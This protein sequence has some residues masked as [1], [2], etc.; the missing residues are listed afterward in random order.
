MM[1]KTDGKRSLLCVAGLFVSII[2]P[3]MLFVAR[4]LGAAYNNYTFGVQFAIVLALIM[5][6]GGLAL[7]IAGVVIARKHD[8]RG[9][10]SGIVG[11]IISGVEVLLIILLVIFMANYLSQAHTTPP[12]YTIAR[13]N[14][15]DAVNVKATIESVLNSDSEAEQTFA[16]KSVE[17][18]FILGYENCYAEVENTGPGHYSWRIYNSE[19][20]QIAC[21]FGFSCEDTPDIVIVDVDGDDYYLGTNGK[22]VT[23]WFR[24]VDKYSGYVYPEYHYADKNGVIAYNKWLTID[25]KT[26]YID[27]QGNM[28]TG[29]MFIYG[30][31]F[32]FDDN[33][34]C[35]NPGVG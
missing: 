27:S 7:S 29:M 4:I 22:L 34:V 18:G 10:N 15:E 1:N 31:M 9:V 28:V 12:D 5:P 30:I 16:T 11:I 8:L 25:G 3:V 21:Q 24:E 14:P 35:L 33:G 23:G 19:G 20:Q 32:E 2:A 13:H 26:Y 17:L 6:L